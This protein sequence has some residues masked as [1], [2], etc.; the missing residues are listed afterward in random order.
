MDGIRMVNKLIQTNDLVYLRDETRK[1]MPDLVDIQRK[2][3]E[4]DKQG[5]FT[6]SWANAYEQVAAR[7]AAKGGSESMTAGRQ[8]LQLDFTLAVGYD[9][10]V[11][12]TDRIIHSSGTY[13]VQS[14]DDGKSWAISKICQMRR[15]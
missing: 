5:G 4:S 7:I 2:T 14:V 1:S 9:Q 6:E 11:L 10:S 13:E 12:Q 15:L 8:D 3:N